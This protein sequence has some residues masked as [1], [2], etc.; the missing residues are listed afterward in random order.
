MV[1]ILWFTSSLVNSAPLCNNF[2]TS[3]TLPVLAAFIN[4]AHSISSVAIVTL[5]NSHYYTPTIK[6]NKSLH[7]TYCI[8]LYIGN[9][10]LMAKVWSFLKA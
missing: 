6:Y 9:L 10:F 7:S 2:L 3:F 5:D 8:D 1:E 4:W